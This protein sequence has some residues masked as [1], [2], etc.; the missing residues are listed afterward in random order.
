MTVKNARAVGGLDGQK[1]EFLAENAFDTS[2]HVVDVE[3]ASG[4]D[5]F[6]ST[7]KS[8]PG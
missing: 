4:Q 5:S 8:T 3:A 2:A 1:F 6:Q 7:P